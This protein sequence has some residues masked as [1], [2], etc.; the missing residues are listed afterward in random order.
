M[1]YKEIIPIGNDCLG[2]MTLRELNKRINGYPFDWLYKENNDFFTTAIDCILNDFKGFYDLSNL[3]VVGEVESHKTWHIKNKKYGFCFIH[4]YKL[5]KPPLSN[6]DEI[7]G[8]YNR[9]IERLKKVLSSGD[10]VL[11]LHM[12]QTKIDDN[13]CIEKINEIQKKFNNKNIYLLLLE[14]DETK[15][16]DEIEYIKLNKNITK[17]LYNNDYKFSPIK[18]DSWWRNKK[19]Y[20]KIIEDNCK[21]KDNKSIIKSVL[22]TVFSVKNSNDKKH[23]I[24]TILGIKI[25]IR[26]KNHYKYKIIGTNN[27]IKINNNGELI[28]LSKLK[29]I[30]SLNIEIIGNNNYIQIDKEAVFNNAQ[31]RI[32]SDNCQIIINKTPNFTLDVYICNGPNQIFKFG[33]GS[34]TSWA[35]KVHLSNTNSKIIIGEDCMIAGEVDIWG[36]DAHYIYDTVTNQIINNNTKPIIIGNHVWIGQGVKILKNAHISDNTIIGGSSVVTKCFNEN[37]V[38]IAGNPAKIIRRNVNWKR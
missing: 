5:D 13:V 14:H 29:K 24:I 34:T 1:Y 6:Y 33:K 32:Y 12:S 16:E 7:L 4:D 31:F 22:N 17:V 15:T 19:I 8:K 10:K 9:R 30:K 36:S 23:K 18:N 27:H 25:N 37:N 20:T 38:A 28:E 3:E 11:L 21:L 35:G 26:I 2:A